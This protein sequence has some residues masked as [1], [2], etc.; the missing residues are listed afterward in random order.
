MLVNFTARLNRFINEAD[1]SPLP[2]DFDLSDIKSDRCK[3]NDKGD[4]GPAIDLARIQS[5]QKNIEKEINVYD[6]ASNASTGTMPV[7]ARHS[8]PKVPLLNPRLQT[9]IGSK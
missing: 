4:L 6:S 7:N 1:Q 3:E 9:T 8:I 2:H 5:W